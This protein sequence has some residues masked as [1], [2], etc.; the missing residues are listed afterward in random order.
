MYSNEEM[1]RMH[2]EYWEAKT[3]KEIQVIYDKAKEAAEWFD[4]ISASWYGAGGVE[5][6]AYRHA[7]R[8][9]YGGFDSLPAP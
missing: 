9:D 5:A 8:E 2:R 6:L 3:P 7:R 1:D 4:T